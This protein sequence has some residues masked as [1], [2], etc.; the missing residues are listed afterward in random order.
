M[1]TQLM[2][3]YIELVN[4]SWSFPEHRFGLECA[5]VGL[6]GEVGEIMNG[7]M[8][9]MRE[10]FHPKEFFD[11]GKRHEWLKGELGGVLWFWVASCLSIGVDPLD[12]LR[13]NSRKI[14]D[15]MER[16]VIKGD[17]DER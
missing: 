7:M 9:C 16:G 6:A 5:T 3:D 1:S 2:D 8:K 10:D 4:Q 13:E 12:V 14:R 11:G 15:R 17:G